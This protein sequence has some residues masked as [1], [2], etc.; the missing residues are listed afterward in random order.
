[1]GS[2]HHEEEVIRA[3]GESGLRA[4]AGKAMMDVNDLYP[5]LRESTHAALTSTRS[6][7]EQYH[8][9]YDGRVRYAVAPRFV[10]SCSEELLLGTR[11]MMSS[12][13]G[14]LFH[15]HASENT[16]E[17][18]AVRLRCKME[19]IEYLHH[20]GL[21]SHRSCL[22]HCIHLTDEEIG[23]LA[24]THTNVAHCPSS[25]LKLASGIAK[26][27]CLMERGINI[28]LGADGAPCNNSLDMFREM[29]LASL[30]QKPVHGPTS[31]PAR[32]VFTMATSAGAK[33]LGMERELGSIE[34]GKKADLVLLNLSHAW[35]PVERENIYS[36][37]VYSGSPENV[38]SVMI[39]G[40]WIYRKK[41]FT[42]IDVARVLR[43]AALELNH[44]L[45]RADVP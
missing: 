4:F 21:L 12:F 17:V 14:V 44:L 40:T 42:G 27:P 3:I 33:A 28:S 26:I 15:A 41:E 6:L 1:M 30:I 8:A 25:N 45:A 2:I 11:E 36:S 13:D 16:A 18:D 29:R 9:S 22:A 37:I 38:D 31:M 23:L 34:P 20:L 10:L 43:G 32:K 19:N 7:I 35:D 24:G 39:D 5:K